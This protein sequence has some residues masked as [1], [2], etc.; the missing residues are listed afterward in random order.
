MS[1]IDHGDHDDH[2]DP[3]EHGD[4]DDHDVCDDVAKMINIPVLSN[5]ENQ[6]IKTFFGGPNT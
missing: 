3:G 2:G 1:I 5:I 6:C 4:E